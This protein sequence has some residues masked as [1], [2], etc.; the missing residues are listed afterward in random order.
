MVLINGCVPTILVATTVSA[1]VL[2]FMN[3][4]VLVLLYL[5][6]NYPLPQDIY[7]LSYYV[8]PIAMHSINLFLLYN[9]N[10][11]PLY[12]IEL[13]VCWLC[14]PK[15]LWLDDIFI[16]L[17]AFLVY[18]EMLQPISCLV[19]VGQSGTYIFMLLFIAPV[20][21]ID[22]TRTRCNYK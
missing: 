20:C 15:C 3:P 18:S 4:G 6:V 9:S 2:C 8:L 14:E 10:V 7:Y 21:R 19:K 16:L 5:F 12:F 1:F 13:V 11:W 17:I 22:C